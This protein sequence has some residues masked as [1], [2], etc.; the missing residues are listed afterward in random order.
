MGQRAERMVQRAKP[1]EQGAN[2]RIQ[3]EIGSRKAFQMTN[4][5]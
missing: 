5:E 4:D 3:D 2:I 1:M